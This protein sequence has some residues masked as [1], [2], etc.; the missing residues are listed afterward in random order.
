MCAEL[1]P[2][3]TILPDPT[4]TEKNPLLKAAAPG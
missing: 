1:L 3:P 4:A 2:E